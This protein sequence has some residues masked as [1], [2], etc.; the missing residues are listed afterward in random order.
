[1]FDDLKLLFVAVTVLV[2]L[3]RGGMRS[4]PESGTLADGGYLYKSKISSCPLAV[5]S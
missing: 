4:R 1:M 3:R 5:F 2:Y